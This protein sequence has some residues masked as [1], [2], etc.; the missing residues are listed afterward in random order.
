MNVEQLF[1]LMEETLEEGTAMPFV[2][3]KRMVDVDR[4]RD[5]IDEIRNNLPDEIRD[6]K[7]IV[8]D[9]DQI[10]ADAQREADNIIKKAE[11]R[12]RNLVSDQE[13]VKRAKKYATELV[14]AGKAQSDELRR[15]ATAYC[16]EVLKK[17][18]EAL[19]R[20]IAGIKSTRMNLRNAAAPGSGT[21]RAAK[22]PR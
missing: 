4:M 16:E 9:R 19:N 21:A 1:E 7:K 8:A 13:V 10:I 20:S 6:S 18:E 2:A 12:A 15:S 14:T 11:E 3:A 22:K 17:S 5:I